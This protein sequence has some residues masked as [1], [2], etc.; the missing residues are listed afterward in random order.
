[1]ASEAH[2]SGLGMGSNNLLMPDVVA[3]SPSLHNIPSS[4]Y[5]ISATASVALTSKCFIQ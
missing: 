1:M 4:R 5:H 2:I 3:R